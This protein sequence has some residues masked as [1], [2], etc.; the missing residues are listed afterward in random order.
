MTLSDLGKEA[1]LSPS[2]LSELEGGRKN[3]TLKTLLCLQQALK[4][5]RKEWL[6]FL[7]AVT[8]EVKEE[9]GLTTLTATLV[10]VGSS[11]KGEELEDWLPSL[12]EAGGFQL[13]GPLRLSYSSAGARLQKIAPSTAILL[14]AT[15]LYDPP[16]GP[17]KIPFTRAG[18][19]AASYNIPYVLFT[20]LQE[21]RFAEQLQI[22][23]WVDVYHPTSYFSESYTI[24]DKKRSSQFLKSILS[25]V[26]RRMQGILKTPL[27]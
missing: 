15:G 17:P 11:G 1:G 16:W 8:A 12:M 4:I 5:E 27:P 13:K 10:V 14:D 20:R 23:G 21:W 9:K 18:L 3:P 2:F 6:R 22:S 7:A 25:L 26:Q 24:H 19:V